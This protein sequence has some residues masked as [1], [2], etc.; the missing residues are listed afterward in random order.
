MKWFQGVERPQVR[1]ISNTMGGPCLGQ[2]C[3]PIG[4][5]SKDF[6]LNTFRKKTLYLFTLKYQQG[7]P[8]PLSPTNTPYLVILGQH[9]VVLY[10]SM[11]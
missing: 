8:P 2:Y 7:L 6:T 5:C 4:Q 9:D 11:S 1:N 3:S 10:S